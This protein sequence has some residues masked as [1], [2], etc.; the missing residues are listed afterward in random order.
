M[1]PLVK[2]SWWTRF[3]HD[4]V[5]AEPLALFRVLLG[6]SLLGD[7]LFQLLPNIDEFFG[8]HGVAPA[9]L[10]DYYMVKYGRWTIWR[11]TT[12]PR[13]G[14]S[15]LRRL[16]RGHVPVDGR[17][18]HAAMN[19]AVWLQTMCFVNRNVNILN[20]GDDTLQVGVFLLMLSPCGRALSFDAWWAR[21]AASSGRGRHTPSPGR[22]AS[23]RLSCA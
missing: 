21:G 7:Q 5:R 17:V 6:V 3:W 16:G 8:P 20:G 2:S 22:C 15:A 11:S 13:C 1:G 4:P 19:V 10:H 14:L 23:S 9:G 18:L 12:M